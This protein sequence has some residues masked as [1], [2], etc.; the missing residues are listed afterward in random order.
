[1]ECAEAMLRVLAAICTVNAINVT[2]AM[3]LAQAFA[4]D[5]GDIVQGSMEA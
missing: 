5:L 1:M 2:E 3:E 4:A